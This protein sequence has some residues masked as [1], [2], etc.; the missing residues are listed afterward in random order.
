VLLFVKADIQ[1][2]L[3]MPLI[4]WLYSFRCMCID[5]RQPAVFAG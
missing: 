4:G 5:C 1:G 2:D 3:I